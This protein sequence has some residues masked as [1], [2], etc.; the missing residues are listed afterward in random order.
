[1][2][3]RSLPQTKAGPGKKKRGILFPVAKEESIRQ[4]PTALYYQRKMKR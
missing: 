3:E 1:M 2:E 4:Q